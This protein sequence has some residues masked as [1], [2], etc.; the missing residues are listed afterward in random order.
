M[1]EEGGI[2]TR[3]ELAGGLR[4]FSGVRAALARANRSRSWGALA[5]PRVRVRPRTMSEIS[6]RVTNV[7]A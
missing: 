7:E 2:S 5:I 4:T 1:R 6:S 3:V